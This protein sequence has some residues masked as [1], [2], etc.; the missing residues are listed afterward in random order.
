MTLAS[1]TSVPISL[2]EVTL[3][4]VSSVNV[5][6]TVVAMK[7]CMDK[8]AFARCILFTDCTT[9]PPELGIDVV[10]I[11]PL[12]SSAAYSEFVLLSLADFVSTSHCLLV[13]WDG[14]VV[15][16]ARWRPEFL[17][18]DY[19]GASW[20]QF[21]DEHDVGNGGFSLRSKRLM[22][23]CRDH[24]FQVAHPED[25]AICRRNRIWLEARGLRFAPKDLADRF[26]AERASDPAATFG[27][28]GVWHMPRLLGHDAFWDLYR[29]LDDRRTLRPDL[30][31]LVRTVARGPGGLARASQMLF[32]CVLDRLKY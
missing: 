20:P 16:A 3:C 17:D 8:A 27:Y 21:R 24:A 26:S 29:S 25:V 4:A 7:A 10:H 32:D 12:R 19:I 14:Y 22:S 13:Q 5:P 11:A 18:Y 15:D 6:A 30:Y 9:L 31:A 23:L 2:D 1:A 28:H